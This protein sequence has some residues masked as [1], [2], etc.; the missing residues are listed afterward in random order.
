MAEKR[1]FHLGVVLSITHGVLVAPRHMDDVYEILNFMT[2]DNLFTHQLPRACDECKP[3]LLEQHPQLAELDDTGVGPDN[4]RPWLDE[5]VKRFGET[6]EVESMAD[7]RHEYRNAVAE[8]EEMV[9]KD[10]VIT[11]Q[12]ER[13]DDAEAA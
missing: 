10:K 11:V 9:G 3:H 8:L 7:G 4:W 6:L 1:T 12:V 2:A 5:Q 13:G